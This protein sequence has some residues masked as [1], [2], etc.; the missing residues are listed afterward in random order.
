M[1]NIDLA[2]VA[3]EAP[4]PVAPKAEAPKPKAKVEAPKAKATPPPVAVAQ[5]EEEEEIDDGVALDLFGKE[6]LNVVFMGHVGKFHFFLVS[7]WV[8]YIIS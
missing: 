2:P 5:E 4:K 1:I 3:A 6:H 7:E 8:A